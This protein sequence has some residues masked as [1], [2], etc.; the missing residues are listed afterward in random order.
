MALVTNTIYANASLEAV[1][2]GLGPVLMKEVFCSG[3]CDT[4]DEGVVLGSVASGAFLI[5]K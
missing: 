5:S 4:N 3:V 1:E 2:L